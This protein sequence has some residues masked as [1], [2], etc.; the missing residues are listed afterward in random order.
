MSGQLHVL[1]IHLDF[2]SFSPPFSLPLAVH[3]E[4]KH[5]CP[6]SVFVPPSKRALYRIILLYLSEDI[7]CLA[8]KKNA[9]K[10]WFMSATTRAYIRQ[11]SHKKIDGDRKLKR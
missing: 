4:G 7:R 3:K 10:K 9:S 11:D 5:C 2:V 8:V 1:M 6:S